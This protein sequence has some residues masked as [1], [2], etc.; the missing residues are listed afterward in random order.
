MKT[1]R[2]STSDLVVSRLCFGCWGIIS[3]FHWGQRDEAQAVATISAALDAGVNFFDTTAT[4]PGFVE[5]SAYT[6]CTD[7]P[8]CVD[9]A[10]PASNWAPRRICYFLQPTGR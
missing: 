9:S 1:V 6:A 3:D 5:H 4:S 2:L 10:D 8:R 7:Y